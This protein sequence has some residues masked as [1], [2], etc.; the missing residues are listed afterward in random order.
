ME[1]DGCACYHGDDGWIFSWAGGVA[2]ASVIGINVELRWEV[3]GSIGTINIMVSFDEPKYWEQG[4]KAAAC[5]YLLRD[6]PVGVHHGQFSILWIF[7]IRL[8]ESV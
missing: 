3:Q 4:E 5:D 8:A 6:I 1:G 2:T 7:A